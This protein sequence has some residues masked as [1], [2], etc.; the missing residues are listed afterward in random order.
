MVNLVIIRI[1]NSSF[2]IL[3]EN[4]ERIELK[5]YQHAQEIKNKKKVKC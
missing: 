1:S 3:Q 5:L 2:S 4:M